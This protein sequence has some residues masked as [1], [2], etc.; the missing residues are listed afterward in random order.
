MHC[1]E[2]KTPRV[3]SYF[4]YCVSSEIGPLCQGTCTSGWEA[5]RSQRQ[6]K[7]YIYIYSKL[8]DGLRQKKHKEKKN[9]KKNTDRF[10]RTG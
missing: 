3:C 9:K 4:E 6:K 1:R 5:L 7:K 10:T 8:R 2:K